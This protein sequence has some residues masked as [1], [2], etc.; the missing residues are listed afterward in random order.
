MRILI[1]IGCCLVLAGCGKPAPT[2]VATKQA[3]QELQVRIGQVGGTMVAQ[4]VG[5]SGTVTARPAQ[6]TPGRTAPALPAQAESANGY[7]LVVPLLERDAARLTLG[8]TAQV[9]FAAFENDVIVG[10]VIKLGVPVRGIVAVEIVLPRDARL[11]TGLVGTVRI[12]AAGAA[13]RL[14]AVP[15][16]AVAGSHV[17]SAEVYV[18]DLATSRLHRRAVT[19]GAQDPD[20]IRVTAGLRNGEWVALTRTDQLHDGMKI[21]PV[22]PAQ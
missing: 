10:R 12:V 22:G 19:L 2:Q 1:G 15:P 3:P 4:T 5:G 21:A 7:S 11:H 17:G 20:G 18:V 9:R 6:A 16:S 14:L 13:T 8:A